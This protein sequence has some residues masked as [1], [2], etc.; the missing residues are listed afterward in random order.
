[1]TTETPIDNADTY[2]EYYWDYYYIPEIPE[3]DREAI[4]VTTVST[5]E[6]PAVVALALGISAGNFVLLFL[7]VLLLWFIFR[8]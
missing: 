6:G 4:K 2:P 3:A 7:I 5:K 1:M 8:R